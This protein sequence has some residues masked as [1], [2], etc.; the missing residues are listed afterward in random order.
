MWNLEKAWGWE[1]VY[2][3]PEI[4]PT[5]KK[6]RLVRLS[7]LPQVFRE[8]KCIAMGFTAS[9]Y[10]TGATLNMKFTSSMTSIFYQ[11]SSL[12]LAQWSPPWNPSLGVE[13]D[14][15]QIGLRYFKILY[16]LLSSWL[17]LC[18]SPTCHWNL[19]LTSSLWWV[20]RNSWQIFL[21]KILILWRAAVL[22]LE[23]PDPAKEVLGSCEKV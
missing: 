7:N 12:I 20:S 13:N 21:T 3:S 17:C 4:I 22:L 14:Q 6:I 16:C 5:K 1:R 23:Q 15:L 9:K 10:F 19:F 11:L 8:R 18:S 2:S